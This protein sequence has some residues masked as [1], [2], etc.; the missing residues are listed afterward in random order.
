MVM[1]SD[2]GR[3]TTRGTDDVVVA[4]KNCQEPFGQWA[5]FLGTARIG[6]WLTTARLSARE[7]DGC[8]VRLAKLLQQFDRRHADARIEL[9]D[10]ARNKKRYPHGVASGEG[11]VELALGL[12]SFAQRAAV[13]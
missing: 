12:R 10:I 3:A 6:H 1:M 9:V 4:T 7:L 5:S 8:V 2:H 11:W 13:K